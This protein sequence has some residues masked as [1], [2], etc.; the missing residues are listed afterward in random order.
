MKQ[1]GA[2][3]KKIF[4]LLDRF[5]PK[6]PQKMIES[7]NHTNVDLSKIRA[8]LGKKTQKKEYFLQIK[9]I[10]EFG[11]GFVIY[12]V[13]GAYFAPNS[14]YF[15]VRE[16]EFEMLGDVI[17]SRANKSAIDELKSRILGS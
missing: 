3:C 1:G 14:A 5:A 17:L 15:V 13:F 7:Q 16:N 2:N 12:A 10:Y 11:G 9:D 8:L 4:G 6:V